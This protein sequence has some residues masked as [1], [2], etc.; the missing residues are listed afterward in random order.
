MLF[1]IL[2]ILQVIAGMTAW[3]ASRFVP[4]EWSDLLLGTGSALVIV[5]L[6][7]IFVN[8]WLRSRRLSDK[9]KRSIVGVIERKAELRK[10][11][12][13]KSAYCTFCLNLYALSIIAITVLFTKTGGGLLRTVLIGIAAQLVAF[14]IFYQ[15]ERLKSDE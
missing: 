8:I 7:S 13:Q 15:V 12:M 3:I 14:W 6:V 4:K 5:G 9:E 10:M 1:R 11:R 2:F